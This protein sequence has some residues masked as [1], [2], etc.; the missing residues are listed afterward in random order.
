[1]IH[2][3]VSPQLLAL[4]IP[5][6]GALLISLAGRWPNLRELVT[7]LTAGVLLYV[8][9]GMAPAVLAD[10]FWASF[11]K[12]PGL[13]LAEV[14][15]GVWL[16][17]K[18]EPLGMLFA[19]IASSLW[20][21]NS[22]Y[23]IGYMRGNHEKNQ[24][25]F[26]VC[27]ALAIASV[28]GLAFAG[29]LFTLFVFYEALTLTTYPLVAH[30][31]SAEAIRSARTYLGILVVTSVC[32]LLAGIIGT[33]VFTGGDMTFRPG[34]VFRRALA[35][36]SLTAPTLGILFV[37]YMYGIGKAALMPVH[38]WLPAAMVAPTP[39]SALLHAVAVVKAGVFTVL[40][41]IVYVFGPAVLVRY[42]VGDWLI[43]VAGATI[44]IASCIAL[45]QDNLKRRL[46]Y[47]TVSQLSYVIIAAALLS[48]L[49]ITAAALHIAAHAFGK[50]TL[51]FAA[52]SIY[53][54]AH[55]TEISQLDGIGRRMPITM[56]AFTIGSLSMIGLPPTA[57]FVSKWYLLQATW[58]TDAPFVLVVVILSTLLNAA[59]FLPI[60]YRAF[61]VAEA[62][63]HHEPH[64][65]SADG[66]FGDHG[67]HH[68]HDAHDHGEA[69]WPVVVALSCTALATIVFFFYSD[70]AIGLA[71]QLRSGLP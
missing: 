46:A 14:L 43:Y 27:F 10:G 53:T 4:Y 8:V 2:F 63:P 11:A 44:L 24:T 21:L 13:K 68:G 59:Y 19:L 17:L 5:L 48:P 50:I 31:G 39:V 12:A 26:Y 33:Y 34:G 55:K 47:S 60:V 6:L 3:D 35:D 22:I 30:K 69:P 38:R 1:M 49:S 36:G 54:A 20:I 67:D 71:N 9:A 61:F 57:G 52:G 28:M 42:G 29:N 62:K 16:E 64:Q 7:L 45:F 37:L 15:P 51:F 70:L 41:V 56:A 58:E 65:S 40:K 23:S 66:N 25:R 32:F 18:V